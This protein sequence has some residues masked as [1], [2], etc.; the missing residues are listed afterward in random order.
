MHQTNKSHVATQDVEP[1]EGTCTF[2]L[3]KPFKMIIEDDA[4]KEELLVLNLRFLQNFVLSCDSPMPKGVVLELEVTSS[5]ISND[6]PTL[7]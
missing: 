5:S 2:S 1:L 3:S 4:S 7:G 6:L